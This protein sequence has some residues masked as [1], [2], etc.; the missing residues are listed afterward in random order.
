MLFVLCSVS[1]QNRDNGI[2]CIRV[3]I[4]YV[5][6][7]AL[8]I[9]EQIIF[10][11]ANSVKMLSISSVVAICVVYGLPHSYSTDKSAYGV[12]WDSNQLLLTGLSK[13]LDGGWPDRVSL[14]RSLCLG[15]ET[16]QASP[17]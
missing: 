17:S 13:R 7:C 10:K 6:F 1:T 16:L 12:L 8:A 15:L 3:A 11:R 14:N 4:M 5:G 2:I 9:R